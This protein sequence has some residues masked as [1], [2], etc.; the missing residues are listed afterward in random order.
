METRESRHERFADSPGPGDTFGGGLKFGRQLRATSTRV[1]AGVS[2]DFRGEEFQKLGERVVPKIAEVVGEFRVAALIGDVLGVFDA[3]PL[4]V[5]FRR[6]YPS[7][8]G[9][10]GCGELLS[11]APS[12]R[13]T[14]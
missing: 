14:L 12:G 9:S 5:R 3:A 13:Y 8:G 7:S 10:Q 6:F 2:V 4:G 11:L 1:G